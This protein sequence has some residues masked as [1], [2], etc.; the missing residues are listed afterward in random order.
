MQNLKIEDDF[1]GNK[2]FGETVNI[3][4]LTTP[5]DLLINIKPKC[6]QDTL[7]SLGSLQYDIKLYIKFRQTL[8]AYKIVFLLVNYFTM[9]GEVE[10][11]VQY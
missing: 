7:I 8:D 2:K 1:V 6:V 4:R 5:G 3:N 10:Y 9:R 11:I